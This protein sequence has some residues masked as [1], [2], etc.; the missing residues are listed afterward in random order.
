ML[1]INKK[2]L[3]IMLMVLA[4]IALSACGSSS[5]QPA[6]QNTQINQ[7]SEAKEPVDS[8]LVYSGAGLRKPMDEIGQAF[9]EKFN[10][11]IEYSYAGSAQ[12][13]SQ[14]ELTGKGDAWTPGDVYY[15]ES[16]DEKG[17]LENMQDVAYHV[18]VIAVPKGNP[19]GIEK[20][21]D[22]GKEGVK[23]VFGDPKA[24]AIGKVGTKIL[25]ENGLQEAVAANTAAHAATVNEL[26]VYMSMKQADATIIWEDNVVGVEDVEIIK[27]PKEQNKIKTIP[28]CVLK[29][30]E[31]LELAQQFADFVAGPEG[32]AIYEKHGFQAVE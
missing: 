24:A 11:R 25:E 18:P 13:L 15:G 22:L 10:V 17:L 3:F 29:T 27:I 26:V 8:L 4:V 21:E 1:K 9:E 23:V 30:S 20:L 28:V 12:N 32:K 14:I 7:E 16:A 31:K 6:E 2:M 5:E 19:A